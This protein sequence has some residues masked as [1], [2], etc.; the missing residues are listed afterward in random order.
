MTSLKKNDRQTL[1]IFIHGSFANANSWRK[2]IENLNGG[3]ECL[4]INLPGHGGMDDP[5]D[6]DH[7]TLNPEF[8]VILN[9]IEKHKKKF[10]DIHL[11]GHSYGGVVALEA[12]LSLNLPI[13]RL[14]L[15]EPVY[16][17]ILK[18]YN[19]LTAQK[20]VADFV[21]DYEDAARIGETNSCSK[22]IDFWG[23]AGSFEI[24]P[25]HIKTQMSLMTKNNLRHWKICNSI[26]RMADEYQSLD[27][28]VSIIH[29]GKSNQVAKKIAETLNDHL[30][31]G[32]L[33]IIQPASHFMITSHP[34]ASANIIRK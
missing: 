14:T 8:E 12:A 22:V 26:N 7:P 24:I 6:F 10:Q 27:I 34:E 1:N 32:R 23:G 18:T 3:N 30:P 9:G 2:I 20:T 33:E 16:V 13:Q 4:A 15:F 29:G 17:S 21:K 25:D 28:P 5:T 31:Q 19:H 11:I